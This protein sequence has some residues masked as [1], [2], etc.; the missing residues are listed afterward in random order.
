MPRKGKRSKTSQET[1]TRRRLT[2]SLT[3]INVPFQRI[4]QQAEVAAQV[5]R[6]FG[7]EI[8]EMAK[9]AKRMSQSK[10]RLNKRNVKILKAPTRGEIPL[11]SNVVVDN[12]GYVRCAK[13]TET[14]I[15]IVM[16]RSRRI[17]KGVYTDYASV[18]QMVERPVEAR[19]AGVRFPSGA[20]ITKS[21]CN[22]DYAVEKDAIHAMNYGMSPETFAK[23]YGGTVE[24]I[25]DLDSREDLS[26]RIERRERGE[27]GGTDLSKANGPG[28]EHAGVFG[29]PADWQREGS[30]PSWYYAEGT[31]G[32]EES[33]EE[34]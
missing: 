11:G 20:P 4:A 21:A 28:S 31:E 3:G 26:E 25:R 23:A 29:G 18:A 19:K 17:R 30:R 13:I 34:S 33:R 8:Y 2:D 16:A 24:R 32:G 12:D 1:I 9:E 7:S 27:G 10:R 14:P 22:V 5:T 15:G 6:K